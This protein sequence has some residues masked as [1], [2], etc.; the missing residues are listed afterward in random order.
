MMAN[1]GHPK[2]FSGIKKLGQSI[3]MKRCG[4]PKWHLWCMHKFGN[5]WWKFL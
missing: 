2:D 4:K 1:T 5:Y 3:K